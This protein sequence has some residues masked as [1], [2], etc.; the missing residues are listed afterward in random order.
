MKKFFIKLLWVI[1]ATLMTVTTGV[2]CGFDNS[3]SQT[4]EITVRLFNGGYGTDWL[5]NIADAYSEKHAGVK[6][7][8]KKVVN[9][10]SEEQ[11]VEAGKSMGDLVML[12]TFFWKNSY[13]GKGIEDI[14]DVYN[15]RPNG[16]SRTIAEKCDASL[17]RHFNMGTDEIPKYYQMSWAKANTGICYNATTLNT[18]LGEG[19]WS[20]PRTTDE[21]LTL[22][23]RVQ[24][25]ASKAYA[26]IFNGIGDDVYIDTYLLPVWTAQYMGYE[27]Y[28]QFCHGFYSENSGYVFADDTAKGKTLIDGNGSLPALQLFDVIC[29]KYS[30]P[31]SPD[32]RFNEA[33]QVFC[34]YGSGAKKQLVAFMANGDWLENEVSG[35]LK[36]KSQDLKMMKTPVISAIKDKCD[37][38]NNDETLSAVIAAI[39]NGGNSYDGVSAEDFARIKEARTICTSLSY[40]SCL[41]I[42]STSKHISETKD[43]LVYMFSDEA[44]KIYA[45]TLKG[46]TMPYGFD[47]SNDSDIIVSDF[48]ESVNQAFGD[49]T[50]T[51]NKVDYSSKLMFYGGFTIT[52]PAA[53]TIFNKTTNGET[54]YK[55]YKNDTKNR[56]AQMLSQAGL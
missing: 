54:I 6:I 30:H 43:F 46:A 45:K 44:Q 32:L 13:D 50:R 49:V 48:Q 22:C 26:F 24:D 1:V 36:N 28:Y 40:I 18:V 37:T 31:D 52:P 16:E 55:Q 25:D 3:D 56:W 15:S 35:L 20:V 29:G 27:D 41:C 53:K 23:E 7:T 39:D 51:V 2:G 42:P 5:K 38:V 4:E 21:L 14:T 11:L 34:G 10:V 17:V 12:N 19:N 47:V 9:S 8:I 33:Q